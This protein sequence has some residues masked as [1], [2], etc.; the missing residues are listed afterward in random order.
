MKTRISG[1]AALFLAALLVAAPP[2]SAQDA[3]EREEGFVD[4]KPLEGLFP[5]LPRIEVNVK[6]SLLRL[7][8][9]ASRHEDPALADVLARLRAVQVRTYDLPE[10]RATSIGRHTETLSR[11][12]TRAGWETVVRVREDDQYVDMFLRENGDI[13]S[14]LMVMVVDNDAQEATFV[15]I[16]GDIDPAEVAL[17]GR[18][19]DIDPL[20]NGIGAASS[21]GR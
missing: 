10:D 7:V 17:I 12:L 1:V 2:V 15:N 20:R 18:R 11:G 13:I 3:L 14:G 8:V 4:F 21:R 5:T 9:E 16:V 19:F 6:G